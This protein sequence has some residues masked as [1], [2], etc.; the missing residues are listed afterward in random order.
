MKVEVRPFVKYVYY[1]EHIDLGRFYDYKTANSSTITYNKTYA[2]FSGLY[3][4]SL[5][6]NGYFSDCSYDSYIGGTKYLNGALE[7]F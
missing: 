3:N 5:P 4:P 6:A 7:V 2:Q 1:G